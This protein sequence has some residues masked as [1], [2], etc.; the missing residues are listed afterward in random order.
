MDGYKNRFTRKAYHCPRCGK[1]NQAQS[2]A[3]I[4]CELP[5]PALYYRVPILG[6]LITGDISFVNHI[7]FACLI[8]YGLALALDLPNIGLGGGLFNGLSPS[9]EALYKL[10]MGGRFPWLAGRWW[11]LITATYLHAGILHVGFNMLWLRRIGPWAEELFGASRF[12]IIYT[13]SGLGGALVSTAAGTPFFVGASGAIFGLFGAL[14]YYG[15]HRGGTFGSEIFRQL[16]IWAAIGL[17]L[18][19]VIPNVDNWGHLGG[20]ASGVFTAI[21]LGYQERKKEAF[22]QHILATLL[23]LLVGVCFGIMFVSFFLI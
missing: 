4:N 16:I 15:R 9:S 21:L 5:Y 12:W 1:L 10:G 17:L 8:L 20:I 2:K 3:C 13:L 23:I 22:W 14:L 19:F 11:T 18:G 7:L 6:E